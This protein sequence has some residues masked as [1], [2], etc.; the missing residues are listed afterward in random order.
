MTEVLSAIPNPDLLA[1]IIWMPVVAGDDQA[2]AEKVSQTMRDPRVRHY[3]DYPQQLGWM[4]G[5]SLPLPGGRPLGWDIYLIFDRDA[6]W[7]P[8]IP[9]PTDWMHQLGQ[10]ER[11]LDGKRLRV[12]LQRLLSSKR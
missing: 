3:W 9:A 2:S 12:A 5:S 8:P 1:Y 4:Y 7:D 10:D 11:R 6:K